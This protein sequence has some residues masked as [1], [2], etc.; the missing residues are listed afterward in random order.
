VGCNVW[1]ADGVHLESLPTNVELPCPHPIEVIIKVKGTS[2]GSDEIRM[3]RLGDAL[4]QCG[5]EKEIAVE[6]Y[7]KLSTLLK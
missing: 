5:Q 7:N 3:G 6:G 1:N 4:I 2:I